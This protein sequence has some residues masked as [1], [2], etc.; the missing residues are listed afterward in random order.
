M[1]NISSLCVFCGSAKGIDPRHQEAASRL[2]AQLAA[3]GVTL[4]YGGG[5]IGIMGAVADAA[6]E[7]GG[8]VIGVIPEHLVS[9]EVAH[10]GVSELIV[11]DS[12][13]SRKRR[14][15]DLSDAFCILPGGLGTLDETFEILTWKQLRLHNK[16]VILVNEGGYW[17]PLLAMIEHMVSNGYARPENLRLFSVV[18]NV[19]DVLSTAE[20]MAKATLSGETEKF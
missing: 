4:V 10:H 9:M 20:A 6:L 14:M 13:H 3:H 5:D 17:G 18:D 12:M 1:L 2:G 7:A 15:F 16:P 8:K 11:V 19:D